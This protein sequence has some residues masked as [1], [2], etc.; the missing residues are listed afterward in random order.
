MLQDYHII[1]YVLLDISYHMILWK[2]DIAKINAAFT[3]GQFQAYDC[4]Q[5]HFS[6]ILMWKSIWSHFKDHLMVWQMFRP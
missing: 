2:Q 5:Y 6:C 1:K 3:I 4:W